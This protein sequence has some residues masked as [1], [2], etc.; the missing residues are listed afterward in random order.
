MSWFQTRVTSNRDSAESLS[1]LLSELGAASVTFEDAED[2]PLLEPAPGETPLWNR[3]DVVGLF[4]A[5]INRD[6]VSIALSQQITEEQLST[7]TISDLEEQNWVRAWMDDFHPMRFGENLWI[8]PSWSDPVDSDAVNILLDPGLAFGTGTH[9]TTALCMEWLDTN[10]PNGATVIDYGCGSGILAI[11][12]AK[13]GA[14]SVHCVDN[15]PQALTATLD[16]SEKNGVTAMISTYLPDQFPQEQQADL[17]IANILAGPLIELA[18]KLAA[19]VAPGGNII[20]SGILH[21]Q[22]DEVIS[23]YVPWFDMNPPAFQQEWVRIEGQK[24]G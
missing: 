7:L 1:N 9:P 11:A 10:P 8:V 18:P 4:D 17:L 5:E 15:D 3:I 14:S 20:L 19:H 24:K 6:L 22:A 23:A 21:N 12:A 16:N 2:Q 13:L